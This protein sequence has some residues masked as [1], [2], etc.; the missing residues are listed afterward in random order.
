MKYKHR[1]KEL[2][3]K[4]A[5]SRKYSIQEDVN[6]LREHADICIIELKNAAKLAKKSTKPAEKSDKVKTIVKKDGST[7]TVRLNKRKKRFGKSIQHRCP[8]YFQAQ[9]KLKFGGG[10]HEVPYKYR[11][12][13]YDHELNNYIKKSLSQRW[14]YLPDGKKVQRDIYSAFLLYCADNAFK[15]ISLERCLAEFD[16]FFVLH[17][18][19]IEELIRNHIEVCNSGID[20]PA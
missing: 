14:H 2:E 1:L 8:G 18:K 12:S 15:A 9:L 6:A 19:L 13:Q 5:A 3:R 20:I 17:E 4:D 10:Y 7:K 16:K 11:A